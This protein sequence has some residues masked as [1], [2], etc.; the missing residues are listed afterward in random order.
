LLRA[1]KLP[2]NETNWSDI[3]KRVMAWRPRKVTGNAR[4]GA[5]GNAAMKAFDADLNNS[6]PFWELAKAF[7]G[8]GI[9]LVLPENCEAR[10]KKL[11]KWHRS[12]FIE[13]PLR[14][15][16]DLA[17]YV[18]LLTDNVFVPASV[19]HVKR[20]RILPLLADGAS[21]RD[22]PLVELLKIPK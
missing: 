14:E 13:L 7:G 2:E 5:F 15:E 1:G 22:T 6:R 10:I 9:F 12:K 4:F 16:P 3:V 11:T 19:G 21:T 17:L 18:R 20:L 8:H